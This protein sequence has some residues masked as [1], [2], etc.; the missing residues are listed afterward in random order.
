MSISRV[1]KLGVAATA[2]LL[3]LDVVVHGLIKLP[4]RL[5]V[6]P[7]KAQLSRLS[8]KILSKITITKTMAK[9]FM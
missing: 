6:Y 9:I 2:L 5:K 4:S 7:L 8:I 1:I 3:Y